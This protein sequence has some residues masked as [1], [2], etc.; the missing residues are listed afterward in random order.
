[1]EEIQKNKSSIITKIAAIIML[2]LGVYFG[3][4]QVFFTI[5]YMGPTDVISNNLTLLSSIFLIIFSIFLFKNKKWAWKYSI[6]TLFALIFIIALSSVSATKLTSYEKY[7]TPKWS[8]VGNIAI[9]LSFAAIVLLL[10]F[11][12]IKTEWAWGILII[13]ILANAFL[14]IQLIELAHVD[15]SNLWRISDRAEL[16]IP[17]AL[18]L[19]LL[20]L[21]KKN[22]LNSP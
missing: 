3:P 18:P 12:K 6:F 13:L 8:I 14:M 19:I 10:L 2:V 21:D 11:L 16:Y 5:G 7:F 22:Y 17:F 4:V 1:M 9:A 15:G 20:L